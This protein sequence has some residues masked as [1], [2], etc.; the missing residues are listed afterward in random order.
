MDFVLGVTLHLRALFPILAC[1]FFLYLL[2]GAF[3]KLY[4]SP[5]AGFPGPKLTA[6]TYWVELYYDLVKGG[7][8]P[9]RIAQWHDQYG[10]TIHYSLPVT[11]FL[12]PV[13]IHIY[14]DPSSESLPTNSI[15][16]TPISTTSSIVVRTS[17]TNTQ[18]KPKGLAFQGYWSL[19]TRAKSIGIAAYHS[20]RI[21]RKGRGR[22]VRR[23][24]GEA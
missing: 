14:Q 11:S 19:L 7:R 17:S 22:N 4:L 23:H 1:L 9:H 2:A 10:K 18:G 12:P 15:S 6:L 21:S 13:V 8:F 3:Y 16:G 20:H 5:L 24:R